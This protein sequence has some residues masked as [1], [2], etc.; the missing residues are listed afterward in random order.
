MANTRNKPCPCKSGKKSKYCCLGHGNHYEA[1]YEAASKRKALELNPYSNH[2][3]PQLHRQWAKGHNA[4]TNEHGPILRYTHE[5]VITWPEGTLNGSNDISVDQHDS[6]EA[7]LHVC[8]R[9]QKGGM[10]LDGKVFP[11]D[12]MVRKIEDKPKQQ[13]PRR[14]SA[15]L[16]ALAGCALTMELK[17]QGSNPYE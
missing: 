12:T 11:I 3:E 14:S 5:S 15:A 16:A 17:P 10:G 1:G 8:Q 6:R 7:A 4:Y 9:I 13:R 2:R